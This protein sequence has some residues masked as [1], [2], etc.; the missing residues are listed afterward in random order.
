MADMGFGLSPEDVRYTAFRIADASGR[1]HLV[2]NGMA[3][4]AWLEGFRAR[5]PHL[6]VCTAQSLSH[7]WAACAS[8]DTISDFFAK[9]GA[10]CAWLNILNKPMQII[11]AD[12]TSS[13]LEGL[14]HS[15][16]WVNHEWREYK[17]WCRCTGQNGLCLFFFRWCQRPDIL[18]PNLSCLFS[19]FV[20]NS[21]SVPG[22]SFH[23]SGNGWVTQELSLQKSYVSYFRTDLG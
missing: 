13:L 10:V 21:N 19:R 2:Q 20:H 8:E 18:S 23:C 12:E 7:S 6:A 11:N 16:P 22:T 14:W 4:Y 17:A 1:P 9:L 5:H 15:L 3:G